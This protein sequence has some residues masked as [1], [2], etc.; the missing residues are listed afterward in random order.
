MSAAEILLRARTLGVRLWIEGD[1][2][3]MKGPAEALAELK[4]EIAA[5]K[6]EIM[7]F[8]KAGGGALIDP[9][10]GAYLPWGPYLSAD[11]VFRLRAELAELIEDMADAEDWTPAYRDEVLARAMRGP[12]YDLLPNLAYFRERVAAFYAECEAR[13]LL[14]RRSWRM[15]GF[16]DRRTAQ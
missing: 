14:R 2:V 15:E 7:A 12:L 8:L 10:G 9:D 1:R 4:P 5:N 13:Q 11:D 16:D 6:P 3:K